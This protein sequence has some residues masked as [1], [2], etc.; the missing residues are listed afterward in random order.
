MRMLR[1]GLRQPVLWLRGAAVIAA[2]FALAHQHGRP[3]LPAHDPAAQTVAEHMRDVRFAVAGLS[4]SYFEFYQGF[5]LLVTLFLLTEAVLL[6]QLGTLAARGSAGRLMAVTHLIGFVL[7]A[8]ISDRYVFPV[9][10]FLAGAIALSIAVSLLLWRR[11][12]AQPPVSA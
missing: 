11:A 1:T 6:W 3:W 5:G 4:R 9:P 12:P 7:V 10:A 8:L 2:L